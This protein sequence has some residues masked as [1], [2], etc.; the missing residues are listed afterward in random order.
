[1]GC[2]LEDGLGCRNSLR[3]DDSQGWIGVWRAPRPWLLLPRSSAILDMWFPPHDVRWLLQLSCHLH[4]FF[5][6]PSGSME[7]R[8]RTDPLFQSITLKVPSS[9]SSSYC[10]LE[11]SP[12]DL[13]TVRE[14]RKCNLWFGG[15]FFFPPAELKGSIIEEERKNGC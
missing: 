10:S 13:L 6:L 2:Y 8:G 7:G 5:F 12:V 3:S 1:M 14:A 15:H 4:F 11:P 9:C